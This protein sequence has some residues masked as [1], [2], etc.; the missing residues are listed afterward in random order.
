V[1][2]TAEYAERLG[3]RLIL[4]A[5]TSGNAVGT[6]GV[7][8]ALRMSRAVEMPNFRPLA[9][10]RHTLSAQIVGSLNTRVVAAKRTILKPENPK[11]PGTGANRGNGESERSG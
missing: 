5:I 3:L 4:M 11:E 2:G 6:L 1:T 9:R 10:S 7:L 8:A